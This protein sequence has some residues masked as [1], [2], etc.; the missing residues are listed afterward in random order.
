MESITRHEK[1]NEAA[2]AVAIDRHRLALDKGPDVGAHI[3]LALAHLNLNQSAEALPHLREACRL[4]PGDHQLQD[5]FL[6][7]RRRKLVIIADEDEALRTRIAQLLESH[8]LRTRPASNGF[9]ALSLVEEEMPDLILAST[10][11]PRMG[12]HELCKVIRHNASTRGVPVVLLVDKAGLVEKTRGRAVGATDFV[13]RPVDT[14]ALL[15]QLKTHL[16]DSTL[17]D[18]KL[19]SKNMLRI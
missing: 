19:S 6:A 3:A 9:Q 16:P 2:L 18:P 8:R 5:A 12:G 17:P 13:S 4:R 14:D 1:V 7:L 11:M 10:S 15:R